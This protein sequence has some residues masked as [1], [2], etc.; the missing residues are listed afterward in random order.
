MASAPEQI[1]EGVSS[2]SLATEGT[3]GHRSLLDWEAE[4]LA[5]HQLPLLEHQQTLCLGPGQWWP[6]AIFILRPAKMSSWP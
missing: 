2:S 3:L 5:E 6:L 1:G 4:A